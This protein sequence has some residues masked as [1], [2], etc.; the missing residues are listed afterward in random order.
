MKNH[1]GVRLIRPSR[2]RV[3]QQALNPDPKAIQQINFTRNRDRT[4][5]TTMFFIIEEAKKTK[6]NFSKETVKEEIILL[7]I[8][9]MQNGTI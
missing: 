3:K 8:I 2:F 6:F 7:N 9:L 5:N 4:G 1:K